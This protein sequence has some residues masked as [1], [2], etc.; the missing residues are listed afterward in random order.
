MNDKA[1]WKPSKFVYRNGRLRASRNPKEVGIGSRLM[2]D[3]IA[4]F[5]DTHLGRHAKG[6]L[7]DLG[8]GKV[9][10]YEAY[11]A[12]VEDNTCVDWDNSLH[13]NIYLDLSAD[14]NE[15]LPL[16]D[17]KF[18]TII[19]SDVLEHI[20]EPR[21]LWREMNRV[22]ADNGTLLLNVPFYYWLHELP[23][24]YFRYTKYAL[25][26]MADES[27]F[28]VVKLEPLGGVPEIL[29]DILSKILVGV[30]IIGK[31]TAKAMQTS[32]GL[33]I[34]SGLGKKISRKTAKKF[35]FGYVLI[36]KKIAS[37]ATAKV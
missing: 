18:D 29:T 31:I 19:L 26:A 13:K 27:G 21:L 4:Q 14:L 2:A 3:L 11:R 37:P 32:T 10:F 12:H 23:H 24:D 16:E 20:R 36:A 22:M 35:P 15:P 9:P 25:A 28:E 17:R 34:K 33:F 30:P 7:L 1:Q 5:Y 8:C 6:H